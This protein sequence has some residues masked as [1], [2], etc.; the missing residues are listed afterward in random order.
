MVGNTPV[1]TLSASVAAQRWRDVRLWETQSSHTAC[2][3]VRP[4]IWEDYWDPAA[5]PLTGLRAAEQRQ[6]RQVGGLPTAG[7]LPH[8]NGVATK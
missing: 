7:P 3:P 8:A 5:A 1:L 4:P 6:L 2:L